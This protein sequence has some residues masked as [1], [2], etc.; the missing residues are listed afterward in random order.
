MENPHLRPSTSMSHS[1][2]KRLLPLCNR[3]NT[4]DLAAVCL[5]FVPTDNSPLYTD[6]FPLSVSS[7]CPLETHDRLLQGDRTVQAK[8]TSLFMDR[9]FPFTWT[10]PGKGDSQLLPLLSQL[11]DFT[12]KAMYT[13]LF[14][15]THHNLSTRR[16]AFSNWVNSMSLMKSGERAHLRLLLIQPHPP[17]REFL[18]SVM[19]VLGW[20]PN[21][22]WN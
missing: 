11:G 1:I 6:C 7:F 15:N 13:H 12:R 18:A 2:S 14:T 8:G 9:H 22:I 5:I 20:P 17:Y 3:H 10:L 16:T 21:Y 19:A 4:T